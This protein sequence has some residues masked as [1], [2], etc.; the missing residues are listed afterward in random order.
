MAKKIELSEEKWHE[1]SVAGTLA[2]IFTFS[3]SVAKAVDS[4]TG[5]GERTTYNVTIDGVK[6]SFDNEADRDKKAK[7]SI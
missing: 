2:G 5:G 6:H 7:E 3:E 1:T 4:A